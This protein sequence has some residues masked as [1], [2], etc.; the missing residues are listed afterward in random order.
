MNGRFSA[1]AACFKMRYSI[2]EGPRHGVCSAACLRDRVDRHLRPSHNGSYTVETQICQ[3]TSDCRLPRE[4]VH[5]TFKEERIGAEY[6]LMTKENGMSEIHKTNPQELHPD[7]PIEE[8]LG[9]IGGAQPKLLLKRGA[10]GTYGVPSRSPEEIMHR[11]TVADDIADQLVDYFKRKKREYPDW[12]DEKN[13][14]RIRLALIN[15]ADEG[16]WPFTDS[17]QEWIMARLRERSVS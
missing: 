6:F 1:A 2:V 13:Y 17:E 12:T 10:N 7:F 3:A 8:I 5:G 11:F 4:K 9:A 14:E 15:K 16:K